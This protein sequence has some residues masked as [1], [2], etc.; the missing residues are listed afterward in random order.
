MLFLF[1]P[2]TITAL[3]HPKHCSIHHLNCFSPTAR[4]LWRP[5]KNF[6]TAAKYLKK[7]PTKFLCPFFI[8]VARDPSDHRFLVL[9]IT[10]SETRPV[11]DS[12]LT[13]KVEQNK[14]NYAL[15]RNRTK[16]NTDCGFFVCCSGVKKAVI[17]LQLG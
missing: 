8:P 4:I 16:K 12:H 17:G 2:I 5:P 9:E 7:A 1:H 13:L 11:C 10:N 6:Q 14:P 15:I 3:K